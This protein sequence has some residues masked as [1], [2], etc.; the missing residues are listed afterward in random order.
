[1]VATRRT[2]LLESDH[3]WRWVTG[4]TVK[5]A[6]SPAHWL[7]RAMVIMGWVAVDSALRLGV[8]LPRLASLCRVPLAQG[9]VASSGTMPGSIAGVSAGEDGA[10]LP[11]AVEFSTA[12]SRRVHAA[13]VLAA[14]WPLGIGPCLRLSLVAGFVL[15]RHRPCLVLGVA[16]ASDEAFAA[17][18]WLELHDGTLFG[19]LQGYLPLGHPT[20]R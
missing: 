10:V 19:Y 6:V 15:R 9:T 8:S 3:L 18:A 4:R 17:H 7:D 11:P 14:R 2:S 13:Q 20:E 12:E 16:S 5:M 1:M